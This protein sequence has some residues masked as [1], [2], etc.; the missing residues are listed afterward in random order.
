MP[1]TYKLPMR[2]GDLRPMAALSGKLGEGVCPDPNAALRS[3][4]AA[5]FVSP[6]VRPARRLPAPQPGIL[7]EL[8]SYGRYD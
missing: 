7:A 4:L 2:P 3:D 5:Y 8:V 1:T 6:V